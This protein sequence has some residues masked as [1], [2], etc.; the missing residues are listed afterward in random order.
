MAELAGQALPSALRAPPA[1]SPT[2]TTL[3]A[4]KH[5]EEEGLKS[6]REDEEFVY[7]T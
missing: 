2:L 3:N 1:P 4:C 5:E 6:E 7:S